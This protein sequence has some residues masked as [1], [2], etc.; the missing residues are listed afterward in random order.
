MEHGIGEQLN[1]HSG[2]NVARNVILLQLQRMALDTK[3]VHCGGKLFC[4]LALS[5]LNCLRV[6]YFARMLHVSH[7]QNS[8]HQHLMNCMFS[9]K[10]AQLLL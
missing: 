3:A 5:N 10:N 9:Y 1:T 8:E 6:V 7:L 4:L 2:L